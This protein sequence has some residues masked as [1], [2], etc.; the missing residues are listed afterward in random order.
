MPPLVF[1]K[2]GL[3]T[4]FYSLTLALNL[5]NLS[6]CAKFTL[7]D[8]DTLILEEF[9]GKPLTGNISDFHYYNGTFQSVIL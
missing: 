7:P 1:I 8:I 6:L 4:V 5:E 3:T 2:A 9:E